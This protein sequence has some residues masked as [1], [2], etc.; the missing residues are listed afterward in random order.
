M[1]VAPQMPVAI[2]GSSFFIMMWNL[3]C[4]FLIYR[5][6]IKG[7]YLEAYYANPIT[8]VIYGC[9]TTQMGDLT[10]TSIAVTGGSTVT[11]AQ[12]LEDTFSYKYS[13]RGWLV[14]ILVAFIAAVRAM[15]YLGLTRLNFQRR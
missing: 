6:D 10:D 3:F 5:K 4:G 14:L 2:A 7:W 8:Y 12:Y 9:V 13:M 1:N 15:A 11:V